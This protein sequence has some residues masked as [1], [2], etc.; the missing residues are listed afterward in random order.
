MV[1]FTF[2]SCDE[3]EAPHKHDFVS[4]FDTENHWLECSCKEK[5]DVAK[6]DLYT[7]EIKEDKIII[8]CRGCEYTTEDAIAK[9]VVVN[10]EADLQKAISDNTDKIVILNKDLALK[11]RVVLPAN[12]I[13]LR[14]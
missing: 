6:H 3:P 5:K 8:K 2:I 14:T 1:A 13:K 9:Y 7:A 11:D 10:E 12:V 4:K